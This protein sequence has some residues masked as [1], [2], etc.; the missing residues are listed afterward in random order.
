MSRINYCDDEDQPG[1]FALWNANVYRSVRGKAGLASLRE[2]EA[3]LLALPRKRLVR[4]VV[5]CDGDVCA[6][7]AVLLMR[8]AKSLGSIEAAQVAL[9]K[10]M[11]AAEDQAYIETDAIGVDLGM[12]RLVAW[13]LVALNDIEIDYWCAYAEGPDERER[14]PYPHYAPHMGVW[15]RFEYTPEERYEKL[16]AWVREQLIA[17]QRERV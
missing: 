4:H 6:V 3:A 5:A 1:Q 14:Q 11:G 13:K 9:E 7:G 17:K 16:L 2:L 10:E 12:P 8:K 15:T